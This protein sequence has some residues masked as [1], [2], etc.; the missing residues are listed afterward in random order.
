MTYQ[1]LIFFDV[2]GLCGS[3]VSFFKL[4]QISK[5]LSKI[6]IGKI[7]LYKWPCVVQGSAI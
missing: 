4:L 6:F 3:Y 2:S 1:I 7:S 5:V